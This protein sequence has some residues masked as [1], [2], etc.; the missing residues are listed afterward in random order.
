MR[1][2][3][4]TTVFPRLSET[5]VV[6]EVQALRRRGARIELFSVK[7]PSRGDVTEETRELERQTTYLWP[8]RL[9][10]WLKAHGYF[11]RVHPGRY[12]KTLAFQVRHTPRTVRGLKRNLLHFFEGVL[13]AYAC[14]SRHVGHIHA[15]FAHGPASLA[16]VV[17]WLLGIPFSFTA[18]AVDLF[19][20]P[21]M[22][23][24]KV[25][26]ASFVAAISNYNRDFLRHCCAR[27]EWRKIQ[28]IPCGV[29]ARRF[30]PS[31]RS[32]NGVIQIL[33]VG[34]LVP[35][36]GFAVLLAA[37]AKVKDAGLPFRCIIVGDGPERQD[38]VRQT[39]QLDLVDR[40]RFA[41]A[42]PHAQV[43][44]SYA[45]AD[46]VVLPC[47]VSADQDRDGIPVTLMEAMASGVACISTSVS[48][49][50]ELI[51]HGVDGW[52]VDPENPKALAEAILLLC[53]NHGL[54]MRLAC[55]ARKK[56]LAQ[57]DIER[58]IDKLIE[59]FRHVR[60]DPRQTAGH[61]NRKVAP[62]PRHAPAV[63]A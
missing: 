28:V 60:T 30:R 3:Y 23:E 6:Q 41:G 22:L 38:L 56:V 43:R 1:I 8:P 27:S 54:R 18:H 15:H 10:T 46:I 51:D 48:G 36:K 63:E 39:R 33:A 50:P 42:L 29:D 13:V 52:L 62:R 35:K 34:R 58:S 40:V 47:V 32:A 9:W 21:L 19:K 57:F 11:L 4:V 26:A 53:R 20:D 44:R 55:N 12:A 25:R 24:E 16:L 7:R 17:H 37:L 59:N 49:I 31:R 2:A 5:F 61:G 14:Q 45:S